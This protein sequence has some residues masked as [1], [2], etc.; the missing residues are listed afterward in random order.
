[1]A[2]HTGGAND[3]G[4]DAGAVGVGI[5]EAL[6][7]TAAGLIIALGAVIPYSYFTSVA[8]KAEETICQ[9]VQRSQSLRQSILKRAFEGKLVPQDPNDEPAEKLVERIKEERARLEAC[10]PEKKC[11]SRKKSKKV[12]EIDL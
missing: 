10:K 5:S 8:D 3:H 7:T 2:G 9:S 11:A 6:I 4:V 1:M 12:V